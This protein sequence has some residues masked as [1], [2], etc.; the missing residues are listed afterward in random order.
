[1]VANISDLTQSVRSS[2]FMH[3]G[4]SLL[5][6]RTLFDRVCGEVYIEVLKVRWGGQFTTHVLLGPT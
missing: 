4:E 1:M 5:E 6:L 3:Q 2:A